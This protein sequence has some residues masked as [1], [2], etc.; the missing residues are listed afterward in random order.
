MAKKKS[1]RQPVRPTGKSPMMAVNKS[2]TPSWMRAVIITVALSFVATS[3][4]IVAGTVRSGNGGSSLSSND[5]QQLASI[6]NGYFDQA[7]PLYQAQKYDEALPLWQKAIAA[8]DKSLSL[9]ADN[10]LVIGDRAFALAYSGDSRALA[11]LQAFVDAASDNPSLTAQ[12]DSAKSLLAQL[13][14]LS[15]STTTTPTVPTAP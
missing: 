5:P 7:L 10:D 8:Y 15:S 1:S 3:I 9:Q 12:V 4:A 2:Q 6:G 13:Q 11:A 14:S